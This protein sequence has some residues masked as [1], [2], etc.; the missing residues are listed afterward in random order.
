M[1]LNDPACSEENPLFVRREQAGIGEMLMPGS[2][3]EFTGLDRESSAG[4]PGL[5]EHTDQVLSELLN[6]S[7]GEIGRLRDQKLVSSG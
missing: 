4:A 3:L 2:P 7:P 6:L 1:V 5:G